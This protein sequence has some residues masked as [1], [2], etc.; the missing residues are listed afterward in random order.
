MGEMHYY[1]KKKG[2]GGWRAVYD[3]HSYGEYHTDPVWGYDDTPTRKSHYHAEQDAIAAW[4]ENTRRQ[5]GFHEDGPGVG[6]THTVFGRDHLPMTDEYIRLVENHNF[7]PNPDSP[8]RKKLMA[9]LKRI[10]QGRDDLILTNDEKSL[11]VGRRQHHAR[12][13]EQD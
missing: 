12:M 10:A 13:N 3:Q 4:R 5:R 6:W 8:A 7:T 11:I 2:K 1:A 9:L